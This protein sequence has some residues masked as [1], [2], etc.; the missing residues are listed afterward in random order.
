MSFNTF[1]V[2]GERLSREFSKLIHIIF[3]W[4]V[5]QIIHSIFPDIGQDII[6]MIFTYGLKIVLILLLIMLAT[7]FV[8]FRRDFET[9]IESPVKNFFL[10]SSV[11][12]SFAILIT[13]TLG[14]TS[15]VL[16]F[17]DYLRI[18]AYSGVGYVILLVGKF[19]I[20]LLHEAVMELTEIIYNKEGKFL[21]KTLMYGLSSIYSQFFVF[22]AFVTVL[23]G[24]FG[25]LG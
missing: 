20:F 16:Y 7:L 6:E 5:G 15:G 25:F 24:V 14:I 21:I 13:K 22:V 9:Y 23:Y 8:L 1:V 17:G 12:F 18:Y 10:Y 19:I 3:F 2:D 11:F 4:S